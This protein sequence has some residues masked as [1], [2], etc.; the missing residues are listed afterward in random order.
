VAARLELD[1]EVDVREEQGRIVMEP[2]RSRRYD[3]DELVAGV[4]DE[5]LHE[6]VDTGR[7]RGSEVW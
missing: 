1:Q 7:P 2:I 6:P 5:N 3:I 4:T